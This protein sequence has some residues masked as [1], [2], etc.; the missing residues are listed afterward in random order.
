MYKDCKAEKVVNDLD[1]YS[2]S[3]WNVDGN[4]IALDRNGMKHILQRHHPE[5]WDGSKRL[6]SHFL[7]QN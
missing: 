2:T 6:I 3:K 4:N 5:Y 7:M 1:G